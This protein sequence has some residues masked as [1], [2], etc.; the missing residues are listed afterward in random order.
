[1]PHLAGGY[2]LESV[3]KQ[4]KRWFKLWSYTNRA[5]H[6]SFHLLAP[7]LVLLPAA[8]G[9]EKA[10]DLAVA[11]EFQEEATVRL[12]LPAGPMSRP[13]S[14][15]LLPIE[16]QVP[17]DQIDTAQ[18]VSIEQRV[19]IRITPHPAALPLNPSVIGQESDGGAARYIERKIGKCVPVESIR[20]VKPVG[21]G[22][23]LLL[24]R[25]RRMLTAEL[26]KGCQARDYYSG[27]LVAKNSDG[28][29]CTGRDELR[30]RSG[31][32]C[33]VS[34]FRQIVELGD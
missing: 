10:R 33:Q 2:R 20:S 4:V 12:V 17:Y 21:G 9:A 23:L 24:M 30:A 31:L 11:G 18:Q 28:M 14:R 8:N 16:Q 13:I 7:L 19:T 26:K 22:K 25:D 6:F 34:G 32:S 5:M 27:F 15:D 3:R 1:M 29:I